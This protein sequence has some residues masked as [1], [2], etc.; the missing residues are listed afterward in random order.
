[1]KTKLTCEDESTSG[2]VSLLAS[3]TDGPTIHLRYKI[4]IDESS[5]N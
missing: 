4:K 2:Y 3:V 5:K 1:M